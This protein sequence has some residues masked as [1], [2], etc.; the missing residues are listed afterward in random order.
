MAG[1]MVN[2]TDGVNTVNP[3]ITTTTTQSHQVRLH[4][5]QPTSTSKPITAYSTEKSS[6]YQ[7]HHS[8]GKKKTSRTSYKHGHAQK[9]GKPKDR[10]SH[11]SD[12]GNPLQEGEVYLTHLDSSHEEWISQVQFALQI[13]CSG[14]SWGQTSTTA[15]NGQQSLA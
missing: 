3:T 1:T 13:P 5:A 8:K 11:R 7:Q 10:K 2:M 4:A 6:Y 12:C 14:R 15:A 9:P